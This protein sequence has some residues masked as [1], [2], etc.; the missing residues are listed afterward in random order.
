M[1]DKTKEYIYKQIE[2]YENDLEKCEKTLKSF[3]S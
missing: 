3:I 1:D 2:E